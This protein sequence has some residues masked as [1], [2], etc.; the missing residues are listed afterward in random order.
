MFETHQLGMKMVNYRLPIWNQL[1]DAAQN[2][3]APINAI[4]RLEIRLSGAWANAKTAGR[5]GVTFR[6][7]QI[8]RL[9]SGKSIK[10]YQDSVVKSSGEIR[11]K[12]L[13]IQ[14]TATNQPVTFWWFE[15]RYIWAPHGC[16]QPQ[17]PL[18]TGEALRAGLTS[19]TIAWHCRLP[20]FLLSSTLKYPALHSLP[21]AHLLWLGMHASPRCNAIAAVIACLVALCGLEDWWGICPRMW[22]EPP[23]PPFIPSIWPMPPVPPCICPLAM[24]SEPPIGA[25]AWVDAPIDTAFSTLR[26]L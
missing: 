6:W 3:R 21:P 4:R 12:C 1:L 19:R 15:A 26:Q 22:P 9:L 23:M 17:G 16:F 2:T 18:L 11:W 20:S 24:C 25:G 13:K 5:L 14:L 10:R 7:V 8:N